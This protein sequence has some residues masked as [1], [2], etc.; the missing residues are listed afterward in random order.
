[1]GYTQLTCLEMESTTISEQM[2][3]SQLSSPVEG[4]RIF[5]Q[6]QCVIVK[7]GVVCAL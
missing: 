7:P 5:R 1:M 2:M 3:I 4:Y 6:A